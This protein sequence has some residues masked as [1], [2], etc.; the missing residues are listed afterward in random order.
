LTGFVDAGNDDIYA[1]NDN[2]IHVFY[3]NN[4]RT[5][6]HNPI[7]Q[8]ATLHVPPL[9]SFGIQQD[10]NYRCDCDRY[11][12]SNCLLNLTNKDDYLGFSYNN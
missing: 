3:P 9:D 11:I 5:R 6:Y 2:R 8:V 1:A 4:R 7:G 10:Q 12:A